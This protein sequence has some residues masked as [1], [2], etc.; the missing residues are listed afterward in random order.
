[1]KVIA[2]NGSPRRRGNT[3]MALEAVLEEV[4]AEGIEVELVQMGCEDI[5]GCKACGSCTKNKDERC[6]LDEDKVNDWIQ[7]VK[8][9]DGIIIGSPTYFGGMTAQTKAFVDRV[10]YVCR[11]NGNMLR[12][13]VGAAVAVSRRAGNLNTFDEIN[14]FFLI[15]E[16]IVPGSTYWNVVNALKLGEAAGD[17]EGMRTMRNLGRNVAW[18][19]KRLR[20]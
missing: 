4:E 10:G 20:D 3:Y 15:G 12:R 14:R 19:V 9:A 11:A 16:M 6:V 2:F 17:E 7:M 1:M 13:K 5:R 8:G 18:L